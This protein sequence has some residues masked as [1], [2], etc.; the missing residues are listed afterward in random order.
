VINVVPGADGAAR[1]YR[2]GGQVIP[3]GGNGVEELTSRLA[4][5]LGANPSLRVNLRADR[6][7]HYGAV[8]PVLEALSSAA[9]RAPVAGDGGALRRP[10]VNL[11]IL[12]EE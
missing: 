11:V 2:L 12:R 1:E 8:H 4:A 5:L 9:S 7:T 3:A 10:R 6:D